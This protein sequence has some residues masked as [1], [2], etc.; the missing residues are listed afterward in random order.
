MTTLLT[1]TPQTVHR[2]ALQK[3][4]VRGALDT[5]Y[6]KL[7]TDQIITEYDFDKTRL[8]VR[9]EDTD[10]YEW[11]QA[12]LIICADGIKSRARQAIYKRLGAVDEGKC[13]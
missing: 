8:L 12:D 7:M 2:A 10:D 5:G 13:E 1:L 4:L 11:V 3:S 9:N 6:V